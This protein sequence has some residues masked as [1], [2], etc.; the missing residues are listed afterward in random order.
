MAGDG[1]VIPNGSMHWRVNHRSA[2]QGRNPTV[3]PAGN[4]G[5]SGVDPSDFASHPVLHVT[6]RFA[7]EDLARAALANAVQGPGPGGTGMWQVTIDVPLVQRTPAQA[8]Q[9]RP[10]PFAQ[11]AY[12]WGQ[13]AA[14]AV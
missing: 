5:C 8:N 2:N 3:T 11:L 10:N 13:A 4:G 7:T 1:E 12:N 6:L 14:P 9:P